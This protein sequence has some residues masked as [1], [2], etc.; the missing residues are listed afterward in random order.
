M[1]GVIL[2][3]L[4]LVAYWF[5]WGTGTIRAFQCLRYGDIPKGQWYSWHRFDTP[6]VTLFS[7][8]LLC[9]ALLLSVDKKA[10]IPLGRYGSDPEQDKSGQVF[11]LHRLPWLGL[12]WSVPVFLTRGLGNFF[13]DSTC[14]H[15][16]QVDKSLLSWGDFDGPVEELWFAAAVADIVILTRGKPKARLYCVVIGGAILRGIF[17]IYQG[18][19]SIGLF[20]WGALV[21]VAI[22][23]TG[24]WGLFF[25][26]HFLNNYIISKVYPHDA[27]VPLYFSIFFIVCLFFPKSWSSFL[28]NTFYRIV[29]G[30][31]SRSYRPR[32]TNE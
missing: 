31:C 24:R 27:L 4:A 10:I 14:H 11:R 22:A 3:A 26:L 12:V 1:F 28:K 15:D 16:S 25:V 17:H 32:E 5:N 23:W 13:P 20:I 7:T 9:C 6:V 21:A 2:L 18:W 8:V 29:H 30:V 19:E